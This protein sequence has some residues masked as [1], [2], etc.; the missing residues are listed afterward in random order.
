[1]AFDVLLKKNAVQL[2]PDFPV[3]TGHYR[4]TEEWSFELPSEFN[5]R[6]EDE[7]LV[8]WQPGF[9]MWIIIWNLSDGEL[10]ADRLRDLISDSSPEAFD[11][12]EAS[13][14]NVLKYSYR[15]AEDSGDDREAAFY[16][17]VVGSSSHIQI[18]IYFDEA[19]QL[20]TAHNIFESIAEAP[21]D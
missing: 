6:I 9:T 18:A 21:S 15:L 2:H 10:P 1:M 20:A 13:S 12:R 8:I 14:G 4:L 11:K 5:R 16:G 19:V 7:S 17:M 3:I